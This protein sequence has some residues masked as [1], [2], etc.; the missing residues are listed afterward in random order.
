MR[1]A[2][3]AS[4]VGLEMIIKWQKLLPLQKYF[5][6]ALSN[7]KAVYSP[8]AFSYYAPE[9]KGA[10]LAH[11][12]I[13]LLAFFFTFPQFSPWFICDEQPS[14]KDK[15]KK[16]NNNN[17]TTG[18]NN[19]PTVESGHSCRYMWYTLVYIFV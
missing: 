14:G 5:N 2:I 11:Y 7:T 4:L 1:N 3:K 12:I 16:Y 19:H 10:S 13:S 6:K 15:L 17:S 8:T 9:Q 18:T